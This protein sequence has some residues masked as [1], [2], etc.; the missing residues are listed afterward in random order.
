LRASTFPA[1]LLPSMSLLLVQYVCPPN[2]LSVLCRLF[3]NHNISKLY[4]AVKLTDLKAIPSMTN[5][6][7]SISDIGWY[8]AAYMLTVCGLQPLAG[9]IFSYFPIKSTFLVFIAIFQLGS[10]I[11]ATAVSSN[12]FIAGRAIA[13][14]GTSGIFSGSLRR[15]STFAIYDSALTALRWSCCVTCYRAT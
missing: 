3:R 5:Q 9:K 8:G 13:G 10:V 15:T 1:S 4:S 2:I 14:C 7:H 6:F 12:M 11:C